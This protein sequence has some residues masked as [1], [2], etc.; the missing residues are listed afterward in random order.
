MDN[1]IQPEN[2]LGSPATSHKDR[3]AMAVILVSVCMILA[4]IGIAV[5]F[6]WKDIGS[7]KN[8]RENRAVAADLEKAKISWSEGKYAEMLAP[9]NH[10][11]SIAT[12]DE[13]KAYAHYWIGVSYFKQDMLPEAEANEKNAIQLLPKYS[14]PY[15]TLTAIYL[16][17]SQ[18]KI[19]FGY[20]S[21]N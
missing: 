13:N 19:A 3:T 10:A 12:T 5:F 14:A 9:A 11:L 16:N 18:P 7:P 2:V 4:L 6:I 1:T 21:P 15:I 20:A 8:I 17:K